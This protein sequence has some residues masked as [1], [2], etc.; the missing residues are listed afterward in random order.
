MHFEHKSIEKIL[1]I[2]AK[3]LI[4]TKGYLTYLNHISNANDSIN[5][6]QAQDQFEI[7]QTQ[8]L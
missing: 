3:I 7:F 2:M 5:R 1:V 8:M 4:N 6:M